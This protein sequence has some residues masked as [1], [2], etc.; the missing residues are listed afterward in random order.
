MTASFFNLQNTIRLLPVMILMMLYQYSSGQCDRVKDSL[1]LVSIYNTTEG[2]QWTNRTN[3]LQPGRTIGTWYGVRLDPA[4]CVESLSLPTNKLSGAVPA[5]AGDFS[6]LKILN[7]TNNNLSGAIPPAIGKLNQ[8]EELNIGTNK[9]NGKIPDEIGNLVNL[10]KLQLSLNLLT[11]NIPG[12]IGNL[13]QLRALYLNQNKLSGNI[14]DNLGDLTLLEEL[15]LSQN[16]LTGTI[17]SRLYE[18]TNLTS[19]ILSQNSLTGVIAPSIIQLVNLRFLSVDENNLT[20]P[21]PSTLV[22]LKELREVFFQN[23]Q[24]FGTIPEGLTS[25]PQLQKLL[26]NN[27]RLTGAI[28]SGFGSLTRLQSLHLSDNLLSGSIPDDLGNSQSIISLLIANN[29]LSGAIPFSFGNMASLQNLHLHNNQ[30][31]GEIPETFGNLT[32]LRRIYL[33]DNNLEGCFPETMQR[34]CPTVFSQ[35]VNSNGHN[36][37]GN[38]LLI[39]GGDFKRWCTGEGRVVLSVTADSLLCEGSEATLT[40]TGG[41]GYTWEGPAGFTSNTATTKIDQITQE[42]FGTYRVTVT[43][44]NRC[45]KSGAVDIRPV[46]TVTS[47]SNAPI[48]EGVELRLIAA[49]GVSYK[50]IGPDGFFSEQQNPVRFNASPGMAG[51]YTVEITTDDCVIQRAVDVSFVQFGEVSTNSPVCD[52]AVLLLSATAGQSYRWE[53][54]GGF[55]SDVQN[56]EILSAGKSAEGVYTVTIRNGDDCSVTL[57]TEVMI[58]N[59]SVPVIDLIDFICADS[60]PLELPGI[61]DGYSGIWSGSKV[62]NIG[63]IQYLTSAPPAGQITLTFTPTDSLLCVRQAEAKVFIAELSLD[64]REERPSANEADNDGVIITEVKSNT[65]DITLQ[66]FGPQN[67]SISTENN[68]PLEIGN[69]PSGNYTLVSVDSFG[70]IA[71]DTV[72][73]RYLKPEYYVPNTLITN[74]SNAENSIFYLKGQNIIDYDITVFNRWGNIVT[75]LKNRIPNDASQGWNVQS[76]ADNQGVYVYT[77]RIRNIYG[78]TLVTGTVTVL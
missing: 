50:W 5:A 59:R 25:L 33:Q 62:L 53:G 24:F 30:L 71:S 9:L 72:T 26:L 63:N 64:V 11:D 41:V 17:P 6:Q 16:E 47:G 39:F 18:L 35:N 15:L 29:Q 7:L 43:N 54:P 69:L 14:P 31:S 55:S 8:L 38:P 56:P 10:R 60:D 75:D 48:C 42:L 28:P 46:G 61:Q 67:G 66:W 40:A 22:N 13:K 27:N 77:L 19:L 58:N 57:Q 21:I 74:G 1:T 70:C 37:T 78:E 2:F 44:E 65:S 32:N 45:R 73:V 36:F 34:F 49:G 68:S 12:S 20:G 23:N 76:S 3:W 51:T 52:G 4:G